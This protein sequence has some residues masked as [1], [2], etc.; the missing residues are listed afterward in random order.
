MKTSRDRLLVT[1]GAGYVGSHA[2]LRLMQEWD[3]EVLDNLSRGHAELVPAGVPLHV[4]DL[5]DRAGLLAFLGS[6]R[7]AG[8][9]HF[10]AL[11]YVGESMNQPG[12]YFENNIVGTQNL[13]DAMVAAAIPRLVFSSTCAVYGI[14]EHLPIAETTAVAPVNPYGESKAAVE[15]MLA[16][17]DH[18]H[19]LKAVALRYFNAAGAD[20]A[21]RTGEWHAPEPHLIPNLLQAADSG[22]PFTMFGDD[23]DTVDGSCVRDYIHVSDL[24]EAHAAALLHLIQGGPSLR[25]NLGTGHGVSIREM[26]ASAEQVTGRRIR[27]TVA[28]RRPGDPPALVADARRANQELDWHPVESSPERILGTAWAWHCRADRQ[29]AGRLASGS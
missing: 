5:R 8:V 21:G 19:G 26:V 20:P 1:G 29:P 28:P 16:W 4:L 6:R 24:A 23:Y 2:L 25:L 22:Q 7:F 15:R 9:V 3:V 10:A 13:L 18:A 12:L 14:P 17:Y 11:A 27:V